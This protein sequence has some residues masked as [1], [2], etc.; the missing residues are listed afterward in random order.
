MTHS[1][2][3]ILDILGSLFSF[4]AT[5][6]YI[7]ANKVAWPISFMAILCNCVLYFYLGIYG[8]SALEILYLCSIFY[9]WYLWAR[10]NNEQTDS[11]PITNIQLNHLILLI[12]LGALGFFLLSYSLVHFTN[13]KVPYLDAI[14]TVIS[15]IAQWLICR[16]IIECWIAWFMVDAIYIGLYLY[17]GIPAHC[18]LLTV[19]LFM[20]VLGYVHWRKLLTQKTYRKNLSAFT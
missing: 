2:K 7:K 15:L 10:G 1:T 16:K 9:G 12:I 11:I 18:V 5:I 6:Y 17:K 4:L 3:H 20:A 8:E 19:Y 14:T 13:S